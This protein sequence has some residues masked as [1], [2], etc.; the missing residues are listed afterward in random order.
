MNILILSQYWYPENGVPQRRWTW[1]TEILRDAGHRVTVIAPPPHYPY[2]TLQKDWTPTDAEVGPSGEWIIRSS[3]R[4]YSPSLTSRVIDQVQV[5][6]SSLAKALTKLNSSPYG[7][8][9]LVIGTVPALPTA[10]LAA[11]VAKRYSV[12][13]II[14]LR[15]AWPDLLDQTRHWNEAR[16]T[17]SRREKIVTSNIGR[18]GLKTVAWTTTR[19]LRGASGIIVT[20]DTLRERLAD[21]G[22]TPK[23]GTDA[24]VTVRNVFPS[25]PVTLDENSFEDEGLNVLYAGTLGRA[26]HLDNALQALAILAEKGLNVNL[27]FVGG[28]AG[29]DSLVARAQRDNLPVEF[30][31]RQPLHGLT[32]HLNWA[33]TALV[34]LTHWEPLSWTV[35]SKTY[36]LIETGLHITGVV[37]GEAADLI[38]GLHAGH[39]VAPSR[40]DLLADLWERLLLNKSELAVP[41]SAREWVEHERSTVARANLTTLI[42]QVTS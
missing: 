18:A 12:P 2:G 4:P 15:D 1:L 25:L 22:N 24:I 9:D 36:E 19:V 37:T 7:K 17:R 33:D 29:K 11:L 5:T 40:P 42:E 6:A 41:V 32:A 21:Q 10:N 31:N 27:R 13:Y 14:D 16:L 38:T 39:V 8:P 20:A 3:F 26:Q 30:V 34:H 23:L 35:P 28:G